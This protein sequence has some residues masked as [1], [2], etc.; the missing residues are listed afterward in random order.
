MTRGITPS[1]PAPWIRLCPEDL[2]HHEG[3]RAWHPND[4]H[5]KGRF[6]T[7]LPAM[8]VQ[9][10]RKGVAD[11]RAMLAVRLRI[12]VQVSPAGGIRLTLPQAKALPQSRAFLPGCGHKQQA[13]THGSFP[14]RCA[15]ES[16]NTVKGGFVLRGLRAWISPRGHA[17]G[18][19]P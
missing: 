3:A 14:V 16:F 6:V 9:R 10:L 1:S 13:G 11:T 18:R 5:W 2:L 4:E 19:W 15:G 8:L 7:A 17:Q 12:V